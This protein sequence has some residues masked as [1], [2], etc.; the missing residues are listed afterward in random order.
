M[1]S[2]Y[3]ESNF[4]PLAVF[5]YLLLVLAQTPQQHLNHLCYLKL[6]SCFRHHFLF[7]VI[8]PI[9]LEKWYWELLVKEINFYLHWLFEH[10]KN[11]LTCSFFC[12][13]FL[14]FWYN[15]ETISQ[16]ISQS[17]I[18]G[19]NLISILKLMGSFPY[20]LTQRPITLHQFRIS[21]T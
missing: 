7:K 10:M 14:I 15:S 4:T 12:K 6:S 19:L 5:A 16:L 13:I 20:F 8:I 9:L 21:P 2:S 3:K 11:L 17:P 1:T 18:R